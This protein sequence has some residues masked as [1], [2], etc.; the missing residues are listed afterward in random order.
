MYLNS[1]IPVASEPLA[2]CVLGKIMRML[3]KTS[4]KRV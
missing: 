1:D 4:Q 2:E 3:T